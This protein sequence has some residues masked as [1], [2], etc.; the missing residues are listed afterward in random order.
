M[1]HLKFLAV[2]GAMVLTAFFA[3]TAQ[4]QEAQQ[5]AKAELF[6]HAKSSGVHLDFSMSDSEIK[7]AIRESRDNV[8]AQLET[9][10]E[11]NEM[12]RAQSRV[13][14]SALNK[15]DMKKASEESDRART[16]FF[17]KSSNKALYDRHSE[18]DNLW[19]EYCSYKRN[20]E[21]DADLATFDK[22]EV[23]FGTVKPNNDLTF[24]YHF[25][26]KVPVLCVYNRSTAG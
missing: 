9:I 24:N 19:E 18:L 1:K 11:Y 10:K 17:A 22:T 4:A 25:T 6:S 20:Y 21:S 8:K 7:R 26:G 14:W 2:A 13:S 3:D 5:E 15:S 23:D 12:E 16:G